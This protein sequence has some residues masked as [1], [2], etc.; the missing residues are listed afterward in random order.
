MKF[1]SVALIFAFLSMGASASAATDLTTQEARETVADLANKL[2]AGYLD[3]A[4]GAAYAR[5]LRENL[6]AGAYDD[7]TD[8]EEF[9]TKV[10]SDL[11]AIY[12][13]GHLRLRLF[14]PPGDPGD[15]E[16]D[17]GRPAAY[18]A[19]KW[20]DTG[21]A[22]AK[23]RVFSGEDDSLE[24]CENLFAEF[25][26]AKA[27]IIDLREHRG[28]GLAEQDA[29]FSRL[30]FDATHLVTMRVREGKGEFLAEVFDSM[31][32]MKRMPAIDGVN[33][34]EHW[35][36]PTSDNGRWPSV[37]VY[38]LTSKTTASAAEHFVLS[39]KR[40]GRAVVVGDTTRGAGNF[41]S[42]EQIGERFYA[43]IAVGQTVDPDTGKGWDVVGIE[44]DVVVPADKALE[45]ALSLINE[46]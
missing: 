12:P 37:P 36:S 1:L 39:L 25:S 29:I 42:G 26:D 19:S 13:D 33:I 35:T 32:S 23:W 3:P 8:T 28:G 9:G 17:T 31:P 5:T 44:P 34:W 30:F 2:E 11:H 24:A 20:I 18:D 41:G 43:F 40:T 38:L 4:I 6:A 16:G 10:T 21:I 27:L 45:T 14:V 46:N 15:S 7:F 22:Y